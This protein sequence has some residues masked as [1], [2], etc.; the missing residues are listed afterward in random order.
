MFSERRLH[1]EQNHLF[2][3]DTISGFRNWFIKV[4]MSADTGRVTISRFSSDKEEQ[5]QVLQKT[6]FLCVTN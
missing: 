2:C 5:K 6:D 1:E 3:D 4:C